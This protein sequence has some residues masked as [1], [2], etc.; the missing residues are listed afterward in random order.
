MPLFPSETPRKDAK[1]KAINEFTALVKSA[2]MM[3]QNRFAVLVNPPAGILPETLKNVLLFCDTVQIPGSNFSTVQNRSYGEFREVPYEKLY[4]QCTMTFYVDT[5]MKVKKMF[6]QWTTKIQDP[7]T[8]NFNYYK[9]YISN[10]TIQVQDLQ[11]KTRYDIKL[12]ECYPKTIGSIQ[13]D[14]SNKDIMKLSVTMQ[15]KYF[16]T[17]TMQALTSGETISTE[18]TEASRKNFTGF[19]ETINKT[20]GERAGNFLTGSAISYGITKLPGLLK[21]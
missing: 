20:L 12:Y 3:R 13:M 18:G 11:D 17:A 14:H 6:D 5:D 8:R 1:P 10:V 4:D 21:F 15:Y 19:Q 9:N 2:G 16:E 7:V